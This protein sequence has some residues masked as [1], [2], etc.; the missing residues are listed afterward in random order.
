M[1]HATRMAA[2]AERLEG[3][4]HEVIFSSSGEVTKW[5]R[6]RG[7]RCNDLPLVDVVFTEAG[8]FSAK[9]T[10]KFSPLI[11]AR[12]WTQVKRE[13]GNLERFAP[14]VVLS[15]SMIST[16]VASRLLRVRS[17]A[18]LNQLKLL[19]SPRTP[20]AVAKLLA[21]GSVTI[22]NAFWELCDAILIPDLPPPY[23]IS[24][25]NLWNAGS[26]SSR[27]RY[28]GFLTPAGRGAKNVGELPEEWQAERR[29]RKV[30]WQI[31]G[32]PAT[33]GPFLAKALQSAKA[34]ADD[35]LFVITA[36]NPAGGPT[37]TP[38]P[39]GYLYQ[40]CTSPGAFV[41]SCDVVVSRAGH[42]SISS[43][44]SRAKPSL[45]VPIRSQTEQI[46]NADKAQ[47]LGVAIA[48]D[49]GEVT[50]LKVGESLGKLSG[51][52]YSNK[53]QEM[54]NVAEGFDAIGVILEVVGAT[55]PDASRH[56]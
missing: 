6:A 46:G 13:V 35:C 23:T 24:E 20:I 12:F 18:I 37:P 30:F 7:F 11:L 3:L 41:D 39:G 47:R 8:N 25:R 40:W 21:G 4:G 52:T 49:E 38:V 9:E 28:I 45:L 56:Q 36:G 50:P 1:G 48:L 53:A 27:A 26:A 16:V 2:V 5:L 44:I 31:S 22:V 14:D 15:D 54:R 17:V 10:T 55:S 19:S 43:Y 34:L 29:K 32:P 33:R 51:R 42:V